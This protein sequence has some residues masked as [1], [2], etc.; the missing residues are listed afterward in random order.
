MII[1]LPR[2]IPYK[3]E[4][5][6]MLSGSIWYT[7]NIDFEKEKGR[8]LPSSRVVPISDSVTDA[9]LTEVPVGFA[10]A[11][12]TISSLSST[13]FWTIVDNYL[14][15]GLNIWDMSR[16]DAST[17]VPM[18]TDVV[19]AKSDII[20]FN[21]KIYVASDNYLY[22]RTGTTYTAVSSSL[23]N[24]RKLLT[25]YSDRLY[26]VDDNTSVFS[27]TVGETI[28]TTGEYTLDI[29]TAANDNLFISCIR[30]ANNG[31]WIG[32]Y[33]YKG[34]R[35]KVFFW[36]GVTENIANSYK[37]DSIAVMSMTIKDDLPYILTAEGVLMTFNG[38]YFVEV[39]RLPMGDSLNYRY[40]AYSSNDRWIHP[41]GMIV[42]KDQIYMAVNSRFADNADPQ[43][44]KPEFPSGIYCY[45][46]D[47]GIYH[48]YSLSSSIESETDSGN[49]YDY[50]QVEL[51]QIGAMYP[52]IKNDDD[53]DYRDQSEFFVGYSF[54]KDNTTEVF[55]IGTHDL[56]QTLHSLNVPNVGVIATTKI[57]S[58]GALEMWENLWLHVKPMENSTDKIV[59]KYRTQEYTPV[60]ANITWVNTTSFTTTDADFATIKTNHT[61]GTDYEVEVLW[62]DGAGMLSHITAISENAGTYTVTVDETHVGVTTNTAKI[63]VDRWI[64]VDTFTD[65][66]ASNPY[67]KFPIS[68]PATWIQFKIMLVG[69]HGNP[70][71]ERIIS[72][73]SKFED[74]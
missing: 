5:N 29:D 44:V 61:A 67:K 65:T 54:A 3:Q 4:N 41:N 63:R 24:D 1:D 46:K 74:F 69:L 49:Y 53:D 6:G 14:F 42:I 55:A 17:G 64:K 70:Q 33:D 40:D 47:F 12:G 28:S 48:K 59:V 45:H 66:T 25:V 16:D 71:I 35:A 9:E 50:G 10:R 39:G 73:S 15:Q 57:Q 58:E 43:I 2:Q 19:Q 32:T 18:N 13:R 36:D 11:T 26:I 27:M 56:N 52:L 34:G 51:K 37:I 31:I 7:R 68:K 72:K 62:G 23:N 38:S 22:K 30:A 60:E 21:G 8:I 20:T